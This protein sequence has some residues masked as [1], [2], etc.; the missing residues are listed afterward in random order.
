M[1][2]VEAG[3]DRSGSQQQNFVSPPNELC[4]DPP[5]GL[6]CNLG[7]V[8]YPFIDLKAHPGGAAERSKTSSDRPRPRHENS[9]AP[10]HDLSVEPCQSVAH[11]LSPILYP[12]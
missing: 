5:P 12:F 6:G 11:H 7:S 2:C 9:A 1:K 10:S 3:G 4:I 8:I